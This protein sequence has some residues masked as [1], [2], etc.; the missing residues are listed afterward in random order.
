MFMPS[1]I[2]GLC[3]FLCVFLKTLDILNMDRK[4]HLSHKGLDNLKFLLGNKP[5]K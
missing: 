2:L 4:V 3:T 1:V 5:Y